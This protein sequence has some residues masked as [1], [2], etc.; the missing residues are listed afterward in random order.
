M[1][2]TFPI[3]SFYPL[4]SVG[5]FVAD[6]GNLCSSE[7]KPK[8]KKKMTKKGIK[9][10]RN[11]P[12]RKESSTTSNRDDG[13]HAPSPRPEV[14]DD[15]DASPHVSTSNNPLSSGART[16]R[17]GNIPPLKMTIDPKLLKNIPTKTANKAAASA[18]GSLASGQVAGDFEKLSYP[19]LQLIRG[20]VDTIKKKELLDPQ[21]VTRY[22]R[23]QAD[24]GIE[25]ETRR[26]SM[27]SNIAAAEIKNE[28]SQTNSMLGHIAEDADPMGNSRQNVHA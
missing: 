7:T 17:D 15:D 4:D 12:V 8:V 6:M 13:H 24:A 21:D 2:L 22:A 14:G 1:D 28:G 9:K 27:S 5:G 10:H 23:Q 18:S 19:K 3:P 11:D 26:F 16:K 20:W 25:D